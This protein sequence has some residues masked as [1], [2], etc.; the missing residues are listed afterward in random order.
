MQ[1]IKGTCHLLLHKGFFEVISYFC[2]LWRSDKKCYYHFLSILCQAYII[3]S[4]I[5]NKNDI[6]KSIRQ[7][8]HSLNAIAALTRY[9]KLLCVMC[10]FEIM[11]MFFKVL[12]CKSQALKMMNAVYLWMH[13]VFFLKWKAHTNKGGVWCSSGEANEAWHVFVCADDDDDEFSDIWSEKENQWQ[14]LLSTTHR[15][16]RFS[17]PLRPPVNCILCSRDKSQQISSLRITLKRQKS[18][19]FLCALFYLLL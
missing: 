17:R 18:K 14:K 2:L 12:R 3:R 4:Q 5:K 13:T 9:L 15:K 7:N 6:M 1:S 19:A 11:I 10:K 16:G 8:P